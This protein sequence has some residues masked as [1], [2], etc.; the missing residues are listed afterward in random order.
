MY[1]RAAA[2]K[3]ADILRLES[4]GFPAEMLSTCAPCRVGVIYRRHDT[5][6]RTTRVVG[7]NLVP[8]ASHDVCRLFVPPSPGLDSLR[9]SLLTRFR[10]GVIDAS[11][12][13]GRVC[14]VG[15]GGCGL[16]A[17]RY[18]HGARHRARRVRGGRSRGEGHPDRRRNRHL[19]REG[20]RRRRELRVSGGQAGPLRRDRRK[21][22]VRGGAGG[23]RAGPGRRPPARRPADAGRPGY[24][25]GRGHGVVSRW[26]RPTRASAAR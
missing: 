5:T 13:V 21:E 1:P 12:G 24:G 4:H 20:L 15:H 9:P 17:V 11:S 10:R 25:E 8:E 26:S 18:R 3:R 14:V 7:V 19:R 2:S 16:G 6:A 22:R 23:Q